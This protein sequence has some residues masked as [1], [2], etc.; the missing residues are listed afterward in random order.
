M[1]ENIK[2]AL[3]G[4]RLNKMRSFL[5]MLG[6]IIGIASVIGILTIGDALSNTVSGAFSQYGATE[7]EIYAQP[8]EGYNYSDMRSSDYLTKEDADQ[9]YDRFRDRLKSMTLRASG[10][11]GKIIADNENNNV[12]VDITPTTDG[13]LNSSNLNMITGRFLTEDDV[14]ENREIAVISDKVVK[15]VY[16][17]DYE[18]ALGSEIEINTSGGLRTYIVVGVYKYEPLNLGAFGGMIGD[19]PTSV[20]IP[21]TVGMRQFSSA[22]NYNRF[23]SIDFS[24]KSVDDLN[25]LAEDISKYATDTFYKDNDRVW[26]SNMTI[27]SQIKQMSSAMSSI[28]IGISAIAAISL[29][30]G[31]I[32]VMNILLVSVT[33]RTREIGIRKALGAT[34]N[35]IRV[36]FITES[37]ITC[38]VGGA[39]GTVLGGVLG[40]VGSSL[41]KEPT[42][43]SVTAIIIAVGFSMSIGIF[44]GYYPANKAAKLDPIEALRYE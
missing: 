24:G 15:D 12:K 9:I 26:I 25:K 37:I 19:R 38:L 27:Q 23:Y 40:Y 28:Q 2:M 5:T 31:G 13:E 22:E 34:S 8:K 6:I 21:V 44:F 39:I 7:L 3:E 30:V 20:Y 36:Q 18:A 4:I 41:L 17:G 35:D 32:G 14:K 33:E 42:L 10:T 16:N 11:S 43:P 1:I 29:L